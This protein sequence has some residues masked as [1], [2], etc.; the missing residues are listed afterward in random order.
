MTPK[1]ET[2][3]APY[4]TEP[5]AAALEA[6]QATIR[7][8]L[9]Y[10]TAHLEAVSRPQ[11]PSSFRMTITEWKQLYRRNQ[12]SRGTHFV[13]HQ[14]DHPIAGTVAIERRVN[15]LTVHVVMLRLPCSTST[16]SMEKA[17]PYVLPQSKSQRLTLLVFRRSAL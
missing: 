5:S 13:I 3:Q 1:E 12:H 16:W 17:V 8:H 10:F 11:I 6:G 2:L 9:A 15:V 7:D 4:S 14:H